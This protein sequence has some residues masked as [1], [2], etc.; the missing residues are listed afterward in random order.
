MVYVNQIDLTEKGV[1]E[2]KKFLGLLYNNEELVGA[3]KRF[4]KVDCSMAE[5][6]DKEMTLDKFLERIDSESS[7][8]FQLASPKP[9]DI[10]YCASF[11]DFS[12]NIEKQVWVICPYNDNNFKV[13]SRLYK[14][15]FGCKL[16]DEPV[17]EAS[18][19]L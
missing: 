5:R 12:K 8:K 14:E 6:L 11:I 1:E 19:R 7:I 15:A 16:E 10:R 4:N 18:G 3:F 2:N 13:V 9:S 17:P